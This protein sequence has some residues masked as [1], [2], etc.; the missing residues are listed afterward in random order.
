[1]L[2]MTE[3]NTVYG[4]MHIKN[5]D[6]YITGNIHVLGGIFNTFRKGNS[7]FEHLKILYDENQSLKKDVAH[8]Q[9]S[10]REMQEKF[11]ML[12]NAPGMPGAILAEESWNNNGGLVRCSRSEQSM[13]GKAEHPRA[14]SEQEKS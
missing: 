12:W 1:L 10:L 8:L 3:E 9:I 4:S 11:N 14:P 6:L 13:L 7:T 5:G 2:N